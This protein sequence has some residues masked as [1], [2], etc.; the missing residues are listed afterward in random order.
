M[1][2]EAL[3]ACAVLIVLV[4]AAT[5]AF[6]L[7]RGDPTAVVALNLIGAVALLIAI[8]KNLL[9]DERLAEDFV[10]F[11]G[12]LLALELVTAAASLAWFARW[13]WTWLVWT[14]FSIHTLLGLSVVAF[15]FIFR[16]TRL[17]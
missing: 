8:V 2:N 14:G 16:I 1:S 17:I 7:R 11:L 6:A 13:R 3:E 9:V 4:E 12:V 5:L 10:R 15:V